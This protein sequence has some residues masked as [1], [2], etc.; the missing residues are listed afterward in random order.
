VILW[1]RKTDPNPHSDS[2]WRGFRESGGD[3]DSS[4]EEKPILTLTQI[5]SGGEEILLERILSG[6]DSEESGGDSRGEKP[7][8]TL[9]RILS[10]GEEIPWGRDSLEERRF[11][12]FWRRKTDPNPHSDDSLEEIII[13]IIII[14]KGYNLHPNRNGNPNCLHV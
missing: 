3:S 9:T 13:I 14:I 8:L 4:S 11:R 6:G 12:F 10:G 7:I 2:L 1:R 5:L